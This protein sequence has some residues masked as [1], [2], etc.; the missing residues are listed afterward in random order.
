TAN[1]EAR[2]NWQST[3]SDASNADSTTTGGSLRVASDASFAR[4][5]WSVDI[6]HQAIDFPA[7]RRS[8]TDRITGG[9]T[10][11]A[12]PE[13][14]FSARAGHES[15]DLLTL[16]K[17]GYR[18]WGWGA[19]WTPT[20]RT[21]IDLQRDQRFFGTSHSVRLEHRMPRSMLAFTDVRDVSTDAA[22]GI[23]A[24][25]R[26]VH[27]LYFAQLASI[28]PDPVLRE[29]LVDVILQRNGL[30]RSSLVTGGFLTSAV[31]LQRRSDL[32]FVWTGLRETFIVSAFRNDARQ[33]DAIAV[34]TDDLSN[35]NLVRQHGVS[36]NVSHRLTP[37]STLS[38]LAA[39]TRTTGTVTARATDLQSISATLTNRLRANADLS[40]SARHTRFESDTNPYT[41]NAVIANLQLRF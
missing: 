21:R 28:A 19:T 35:G 41:E 30:T 36:A 18:T 1:Y 3:N 20:E 5:G 9:L 27:D 2:L 37:L 10:F 32:S 12:T 33:L 6:S 7:T 34:T 15:N 14:L 23:G 38:V 31:T 13:L 16:S 29:A 4:L 26:T 11:I 8:E 39:H 40:M 22:A 25:P 24:G 17:Q